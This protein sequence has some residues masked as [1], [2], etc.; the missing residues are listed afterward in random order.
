MRRVHRRARN[1]GTRRFGTLGT[2]EADYAVANPPYELGS[3]GSKLIRLERHAVIHLKRSI[4][5][6]LPQHAIT[7]REQIELVA[8]E[9]TKSVFRRAHDRLAA[10]VEGGVDQH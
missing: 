2:A 10:D 1:R 7:D 6:F 4:L 3:N 5:L 9:A 8:H